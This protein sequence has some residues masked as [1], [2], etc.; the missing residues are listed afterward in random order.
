MQTDFARQMADLDDEQLIAVIGDGDSYVPE[1][2]QAA[3][4]EIARRGLTVPE[5]RETAPSGNRAAEPAA[6]PRV[7]PKLPALPGWVDC[8]AQY[9]AAICGFGIVYTAV[10]GPPI[11]ALVA[12]A[13]FGIVFLWS[14]S[15]L[16]SAVPFSTPVAALVYAWPV[17]AA[18]IVTA[19]TPNR[20]ELAY[21][22]WPFLL[23][24]IVAV[25]ALVWNT[26]A[27]EPDPCGPRAMPGRPIRAM[28]W[29]YYLAATLVM[30]MGNAIPQ[31]LSGSQSI[32][33]PGTEHLAILALLYLVL[34]IAFAALRAGRRWAWWLAIV[35][36]IVALA[37]GIRGPLADPRAVIG[38]D[39]LTVV[40]SP[41][42]LVILLIDRPRR[43]KVQ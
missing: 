9:A 26:L 24:G 21:L 28:C 13:I 1:A 27:S 2:L 37:V 8:A 22:G 31:G 43:W 33:T 19:L 6:E 42:A 38:L 4:E 12:G 25:G 29:F 23:V 30:M 39:L 20:T 7:P 41:V 14:W 40:A 36:L 34:M 11:G 5:P 32:G 3:R 35:V 16:Y 18:L 17:A 15:F 10:G